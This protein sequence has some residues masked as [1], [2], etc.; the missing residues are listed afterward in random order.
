LL[1]LVEKLAEP[2]GTCRMA[3]ALKMSIIEHFSRLER[4]MMFW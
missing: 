1:T 2:Y 3:T 4:C